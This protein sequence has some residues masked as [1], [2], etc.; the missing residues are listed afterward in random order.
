MAKYVEYCAYGAGT[1]S[2]SD[3]LMRFDDEEQ[4]TEFLS[5]IENRHGYTRADWV[6]VTVREVAHRYDIG[7]FA[8][9]PMGDVCHELQTDKQANGHAIYFIDH[10]PG[11]T[12]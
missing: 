3:A 7:K 6:P 12:A 8:N 4:R 1:I 5:R 11:Y 10:R 2:D 9:D